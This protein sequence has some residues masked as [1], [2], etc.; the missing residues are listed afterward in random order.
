MK[1]KKY[2]AIGDYDET[3]ER[4]HMMQAIVSKFT[5]EMYDDLVKAVDYIWH[6]ILSFEIVSVMK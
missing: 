4:S 5:Q 6:W 1:W 3:T 2:K